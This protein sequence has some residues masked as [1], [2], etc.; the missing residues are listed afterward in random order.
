VPFLQE[1][2]WPISVLA[3]RKLPVEAVPALPAPSDD[4]DPDG[5]KFLGELERAAA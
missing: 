4:D 2:N 5:Q 1:Q 3:N